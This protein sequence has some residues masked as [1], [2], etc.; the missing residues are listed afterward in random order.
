MSA[1]SS[2]PREGF[3]KNLSRS[4]KDFWKSAQNGKLSEKAVMAVVVRKRPILAIAIKR[5]NKTY[6]V[7]RN[8]LDVHFG[9]SLKSFHQRSACL[10]VHI[11]LWCK[12]HGLKHFCDLFE[13]KHTEFLYSC[14]FFV[15]YNIVSAIG[16]SFFVSNLIRM[17]FTFNL[18]CGFPFIVAMEISISLRIISQ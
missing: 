15:Q 13:I 2:M 9:I 11:P 5:I 4:F 17:K 14:V 18:F 3:K 1:L 8:M 6:S 7:P 12:K 16:I 10:A